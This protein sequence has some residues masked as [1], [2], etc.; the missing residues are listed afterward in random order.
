LI[1]ANPWFFETEENV[2]AAPAI[3][4]HYRER[5]QS[6]EGWKRLLT[7]RVSYGKALRGLF[8]SAAPSPSS[9]LA[10]EIAKALAKGPPAT[11]IIARSDAT[12]ATAEA[13]WNSKAF[14]AAR[15]RHPAPIPIASDS[16][17][18]AK[19]GDD[20]ALVAACLTVLDGLHLPG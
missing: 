9:D 16:H 14:A 2:P 7:G 11:L 12:G 4:R 10:E 18:F 15:S 5:L 20:E 17:T 8:K 19:P 6:G 13:L 3:R 1:L